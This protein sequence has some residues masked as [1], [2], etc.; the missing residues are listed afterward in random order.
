[1]EKKKSAMEI[2]LE[3]FLES[4]KS[5]GEDNKELREL[6]SSLLNDTI[7]LYKD[8]NDF[9]YNIRMGEEVKW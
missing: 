7:E 9:S 5:I 6:T 2:A 1:M 8:V 4:N 3:G